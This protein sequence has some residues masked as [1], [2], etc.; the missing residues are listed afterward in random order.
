MQSRLERLFF[1]FTVFVP[2]AIGFRAAEFSL[3]A[4]AGRIV[5]G[6]LNNPDQFGFFQPAGI[7][8]LSPGIF[9]DLGDS[10]PPLRSPMSNKKDHSAI[11]LMHIL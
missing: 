1:L 3:C 10:H 11:D 7:D 9:S 4:K 5:L 8:S 6:G 2:Q